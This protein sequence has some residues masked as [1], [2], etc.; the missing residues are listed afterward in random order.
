MK[1]NV[2]QLQ[3]LHENLEAAREELDSIN[4]E[5]TLL[6]WEPTAFPQLQQMF[7]AKDPYDKLWNTA[8]NFSEKQEQWLKGTCMVR[9]VSNNNY[10]C[11]Y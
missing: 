10:W 1:N 5:Q 7:V 2:Q 3:R 4:N 8:L 6:E 9:H 11:M